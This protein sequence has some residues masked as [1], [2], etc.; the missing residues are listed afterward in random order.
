M[1]TVAGLAGS[2]GNA[3]GTGS[4]ARF[5]GPDGVAVDSTGNVYV[6]DTGNHRVQ[7][8]DWEGK[9]LRQ[10]PVFGWKDFYTEPYIA[11]GPS[12][13]VFVTDSVGGRIAQYDSTGAWKRSWK[14]EKEFKQPTGIVL[15]SFGRLTVSD[16]GTHKIISW[17]LAALP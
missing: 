14:P 10:F 4:S 5:H 17:T 16:R 2:V 8:F 6:A 12:D 13:S 9:F 3:D 1:T 15:D 11:V 7:V